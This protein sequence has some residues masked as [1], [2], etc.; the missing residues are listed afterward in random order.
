MPSYGD[1]RNFVAPSTAKAEVTPSADTA[2]EVFLG[3]M[4][5]AGRI[6]KITWAFANVVD[7][8]AATGTLELTTNMQRGP[9]RFPIGFGVGGAATADQI[10][11]G[12][13][14]V[15]IPVAFNEEVTLTITLNEAGVGAFAG[16]EFE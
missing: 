8:K 12:E 1:V 14:E 16:I 6:R 2:A 15:D 7:A 4:V 3:N 5:R 11:R 13:L 10:K 9:W